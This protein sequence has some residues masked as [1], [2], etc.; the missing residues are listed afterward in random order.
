LSGGLASL[1]QAHEVFF[2]NRLNNQHSARLSGNLGNQVG[3]GGAENISLRNAG[4]LTFD[5]SIWPASTAPP[6]LSH[7]YAPYLQSGGHLSFDFLLEQ[8]IPFSSV[9]NYGVGNNFA[10]QQTPYADRQLIEISANRPQSP[11]NKGVTSL[12]AMRLKDLRHRFLGEPVAT[13]FQRKFIKETDGAV[14]EIP[15]NWG[16]RAKGGVSYSGI[17]RGMMALADAALASK[18]ID[19]GPI[20]DVASLFHIVGVHEYRPCNTWLKTHLKDFVLDQ[21]ASKSTKECGLF[22]VATLQKSAHGYF[23]CKSNSF[24]N[25]ALSLD[26]ALAAKIFKARL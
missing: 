23:S 16:G 5:P 2:Y 25:M 15:I 18:A 24:K 17:A 12:L 11:E 13:S 26:L 21:F 20:H 7:W 22:D 1:S 10:A 9:G 4:F 6:D 14:A 8:E 3:R 19:T